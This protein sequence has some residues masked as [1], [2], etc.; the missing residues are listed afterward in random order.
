MYL[1][2]TF[3]P[4]LNKAFQKQTQTTTEYLMASTVLLA[5]PEYLMR[6]KRSPSE[7]FVTFTAFTIII[8]LV[9]TPVS[10]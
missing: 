2:Q 4:V 5:G 8:A 9:G 7:G 1:R 6:C 3:V 10:Y